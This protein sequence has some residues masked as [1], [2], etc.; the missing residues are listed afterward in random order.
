MKR[1]IFIFLLP[2]IIYGSDLDIDS[3]KEGWNLELKR[4]S[5][6]F[7]SASLNNQTLYT[8]FSNTQLKGNSQ[9]IAQGFGSFA[10][11]YYSKKFV[12][13]NSF[14]AEYG[15]TIIYP[16]GAPK[17]DNKNV[18]RILLATDY[19]QRI[20]KFEELLGG[21]ELGPYAQLNYQTEFTPQPGLN[22]RK[23]FNF[24]SGFKIFDGKYLKKLHASLFGEEDLTYAK[25]VE[26]L[27]FELGLHIEHKLQ[28]NIKFTYLAD[29]KGYMLNNY[30]PV[31][32]P[33]YEFY[34]QA[35]M[36]TKIYKNFAVA[37]FISFYMLKGR[38]I[39]KIGT[40][41]LIGVSISY[42]EI[43]IDATKKSH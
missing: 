36:D 21:F 40:N 14:L 23:I 19:T 28:D 17:I 5:I 43:F 12:V 38:Y 9:V 37:P 7:S 25:P 27:G 22:R 42:S 26:S 6:N 11:D 16:P 35:R 24:N 32:N 3:N 10:A 39:D 15:R 31:N 2:F 33:E 18:D 20:W 34:L 41:L 8:K 29:F 1:S 30:Q 13:F 4:I